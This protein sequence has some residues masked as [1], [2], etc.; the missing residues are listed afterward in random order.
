[1]RPVI[2]DEIVTRG[3]ERCGHID[4]SAVGHAVM[5][6]LAVMAHSTPSSVLLAVPRKE[7]S[8]NCRVVFGFH[9]RT[10]RL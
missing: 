6:L 7:P 1:M 4:R 9:A 2:L 5:F 10:N 8:W 3:V